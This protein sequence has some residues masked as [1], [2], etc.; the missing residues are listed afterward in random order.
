MA[1]RRWQSLLLNALRFEAGWLLCVFGG[2]WV[3]AVAGGGLLAWHLWRCGLPGEWRFIAGFAL[4]GLVVDGGLHLLGGFDF[5]DQT[6]VLG[7]LPLWLWMLWPLFATLVFHSLAWLWRYPL[8]AALCG[9]VSGPLSY[10]G[11]AL[12]AGV[13]LAPWLLP[14]QALIWAALCVGVSR[15]SAR[16]SNRLASQPTQ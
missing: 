11:G 4:L 16:S 7:L 13:S 3:A 8:L 2:S 5:N 14:V 10:Y 9:A 12:L 1:T 15:Y 6:L